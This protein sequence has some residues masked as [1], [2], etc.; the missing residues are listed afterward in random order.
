MATIAVITPSK[1]RKSLSHVIDHTSKLLSPK[2]HHFIGLDTLAKGYVKPLLPTPLPPMSSVYEMPVLR[3]SY[4]NGQR[5]SLLA[6]A[7]A[8][9]YAVFC[10]DDDLLTH[11][12]ISAIRGLDPATDK[13][14]LHIFRMKSSL[15]NILKMQALSVGMIA[16]GM[17]VCKIRPDMPK[18]MDTPVGYQAD[19]GFIN[20]SVAKYG[21]FTVHD[22]IL[23]HLDVA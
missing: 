1:G 15:G 22:E 3:S 12:G 8:Y 4:G 2:D 13:S 20:N 11:E 23:L 14:G 10:D 9:D 17:F 18:W 16:G 6:M 5:D 21:Q 19:F 7:T